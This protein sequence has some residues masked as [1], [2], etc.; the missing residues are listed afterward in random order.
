VTRRNN[1]G[2][3]PFYSLVC[4]LN[5][6]AVRVDAE[7][8]RCSHCGYAGTFGN[9][10]TIGAHM[11]QA[12]FHKKRRAKQEVREKAAAEGAAGSSRP[13]R[14]AV[15]QGIRAALAKAPTLTYPS[16]PSM[17]YLP[18]EE[19]KAY[20]ERRRCYGFY[21]DEV[22]YGQ[23]S[24]D[25]SELRNDLHPGRVWYYEPLYVRTVEVRG[26]SVKIDGTCRHVACE[27]VNCSKCPNISK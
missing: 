19:V 12:S 16:Q 8:W 22:V 17:Q 23:T 1:I 3:R 11:L 2:V 24:Y 25:V 9:H 15:Q 10:D 18:E 13:P 20:F 6:G 4:W 5:A 7:R 26:K 27:G 14:I 21:Q